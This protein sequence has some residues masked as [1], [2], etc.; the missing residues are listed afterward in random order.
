MTAEELHPIATVEPDGEIVPIEHERIDPA[1]ARIDSVAK[2]LDAAY[3]R[4]STM[5]LTDEECQ[6]LVA[7]FADESIRQGAKGKEHLLYLEHASVRGRM[8]EVFGPGRW[9][10]ISRR[11]WTE[12]FVTAKGNK[13]IRVYADC[14]LIVRGCYVG[15]TIGAGSYFPNNPDMDYSDAAEAAQS[16]ALRRI[17]GKYLGI[18]LQLW[19]KSWTEAWKVRRKNPQQAAPAEKEPPQGTKSAGDPSPIKSSAELL[20]REWNRENQAIVIAN[21]PDTANVVL[22]VTVLKER[23]S[24]KITTDLILEL[25]SVESAQDRK[26]IWALAK[27]YMVLKNWRWDEQMKCVAPIAPEQKP[28]PV[29]AGGGSDYGEEIPF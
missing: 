7:P 23:P 4:A 22:A 16:E 26:D 10:L 14:V 5:E 24:L 9:S 27:A 1:Q 15:E 18:G 8:F 17:C 28:E 6:K 13:A 20:L 29:A 25:K 21:I 19:Q 12:E 3:Q 2:V 11:M